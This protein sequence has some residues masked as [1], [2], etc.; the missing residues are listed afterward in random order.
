MTTDT[1]TPAERGA[2]NGLANATNHMK[3]INVKTARLLIERGY[4]REASIHPAPKR[5]IMV[6]LTVKGK[7]WLARN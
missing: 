6:M 1:L 3:P 7:S 4:V 5:G 2:M